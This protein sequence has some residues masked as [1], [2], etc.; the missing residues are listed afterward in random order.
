VGLSELFTVKGM[1]ATSGE[2]GCR[3]HRELSG[4]RQI[5]AHTCF[6]NGLSVREI[7]Q[8]ERLF[9]FE[10]SGLKVI[11]YKTCETEF[12]VEFSTINYD[13]VLLW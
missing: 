10:D 12:V 11:V 8:K 9:H 1:H 3:L 6:S 4:T 5:T 7:L 2:N 13:G